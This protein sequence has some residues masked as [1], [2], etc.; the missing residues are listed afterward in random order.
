MEQFLAHIEAEQR[1]IDDIRQ[2][3]N[4]VHAWAVIAT[5]ANFFNRSFTK[6][7]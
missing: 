3:Q 5:N 4:R 2:A 7:A 1:R 6:L